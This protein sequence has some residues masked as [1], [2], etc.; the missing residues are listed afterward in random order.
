[1]LRTSWLWRWLRRVAFLRSG[2]YLI[3]ELI[4]TWQDPEI[5]GQKTFEQLYQ[6]RV[7]PWEIEARPLD[8]YFVKQLE[9]LDEVR[10][11]KTFAR[12]LEIGCAE[13]FYTELLAQRCDSLVAVDVSPTALARA[14]DRRRWP[15]EVRFGSLDLRSETIPGEFDLIVVSA[16]LEYIYRPSALFR[17]RQKLAAAL[18]PNGYLLVETTRANPV[19]ENAWWGRFLMRD[20]RINEFI[21]G[22]AA[23][24][25]VSSCIRDT[26]CITLYRKAGETSGTAAIPDAPPTAGSRELAG[27]LGRRIAVLLYH[28]VGDHPGEPGESVSLTVTP[29]KFE[30]QIRWL[31]RRGYTA[32]TPAQ[33]FRWCTNGE[34]LPEK[35]VLLTFDDAY[36]DIGIHAL[37]VLEKYG[38]RSAVFVITGLTKDSWT[39]RPLMTM[40]EVQRWAGRG[41]EFGGHT[42]THPDLTEASGEAIAGEIEGSKK[43]LIDAGLAPLSFAYPFGRQ[44]ER[45]RSAVQGVFAMA[46][47]CEEGL[48]D[49][50]TDPLQLRRTMV[51]HSDTVLD[52]E[53][54]AAL[55]WSPLSRV[56]FCLKLRTRFLDLW[57]RLPGVSR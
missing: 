55:G 54:R 5:E 12:G 17:T 13:G 18:A 43:D 46:F 47:T 35:P 57:R 14:R 36:A 19:A 28:H 10:A 48:N 2:L 24:T 38:F 32:I 11:G 26:F 9:M 27:P 16:V 8:E 40:E 39:N 42:R 53:F 1:M 7:D 15:K 52:V 34:P 45:V 22:H 4:R 44:N 30:R 23:L 49:R 33:W 21:A 56:R 50:Y 41:V 20:R 25:V 6:E 37:P 31:H 51:Q 3:L 29:A